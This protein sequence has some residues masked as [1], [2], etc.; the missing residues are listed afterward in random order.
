[1]TPELAPSH[2][3]TTPHQRLKWTTMKVTGQFKKYP[4][5]S[6][7]KLRGPSS[8]KSYRVVG[9]RGR[10]VGGLRPPPGILPQN[11]GGN[12]A[13][14][15]YTCMVL[16]ATDNDRRHFALCHDEFLGLDLAIADQVA[17][18]TTILS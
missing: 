4:E 10:E 2:L 1:M 13:N 12:E 15:T 6:G 9:G 8:L 5:F 3:T 17:S 14:R 7:R 18:V 16:K 11:W